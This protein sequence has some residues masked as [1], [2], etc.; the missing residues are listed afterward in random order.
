[1]ALAT[2]IGWAEQSAR[3]DRVVIPH[4]QLARE[5]GQDPRMP[6]WTVGLCLLSRNCPSQVETH[7]PVQIRHARLLYRILQNM[8]S[9]F[10]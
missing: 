4:Q 2:R 9:C 10:V 3:H 6:S 8:V 1:M 5:P 7:P